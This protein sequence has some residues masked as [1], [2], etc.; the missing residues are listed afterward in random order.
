MLKWAW[1]G[2]H[3]RLLNFCGPHFI[4]GMGEVRHYKFGVTVSM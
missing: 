3:G 1:S 2:S 4:I